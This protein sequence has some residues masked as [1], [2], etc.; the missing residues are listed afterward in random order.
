[1]A[2]LENDPALDK[3]I[4]TTLRTL[5]QL[6]QTGARFGWTARDAI[7]KE[8]HCAKC[9]RKDHH[10]IPLP[11]RTKEEIAQTLLTALVAE[12]KHAEATQRYLVGGG[13]VHFDSRGVRYDAP[14]EPS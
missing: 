2:E 13:P 11:K 7:C 4:K 3:P 8:R 14:E 1:M 5:H 10:S 6:A 9:H 12:M